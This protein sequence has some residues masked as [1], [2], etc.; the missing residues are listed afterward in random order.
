[1]TV[2]ETY[3]FAAAL[4]AQFICRTFQHAE[5]IKN[6]DRIKAVVSKRGDVLFAHSRS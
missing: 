1:M 4:D 5:S 2:K 6:G 3:H